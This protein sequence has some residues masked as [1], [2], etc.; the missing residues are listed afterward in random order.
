[1]KLGVLLSVS[2]VGCVHAFTTYSPTSDAVVPSKGPDCAF[3]IQASYPDPNLYE[4][5]GVMNGCAG[6]SNILTYKS[7]I[8]NAVCKAGGELVVGQVN[9]HGVY[10][11]GTV[12]IKKQT[13]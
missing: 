6:T 1:M 11:L 4:E 13:P 9:D 7:G 10:C 2:L 3:K 5:I 12:Y 8:A